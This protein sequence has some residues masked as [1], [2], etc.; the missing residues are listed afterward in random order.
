VILYAPTWRDDRPDHIDYLDVAAFTD[1]LGPGYVTL[2]R[3]HSRTLLPGRDITA[4]NVVDVTTYADV[5]ELFLVADVLVTDYSSVMFDFSVTGKPIFFF[6]P[7]LE[8]YREQLRGFYFDLDALAPGPVVQE[9]EEL[10][11]LVLARDEV[12]ARYADKYLAW[13][14]E[15]NPRDDGGSAA[16]VVQRLLSRKAIG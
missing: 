16:R 11:E 7:D 2:I 14:T 13:Q 12:R 3:G 5:T 8:H 15:F 6:A 10:V 4:H 1:A 9:P